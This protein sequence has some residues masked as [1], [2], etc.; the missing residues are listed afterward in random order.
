MRRSDLIMASGWLGLCLT[1]VLGGMALR[2][3]PVELE[4]L[5]PAGLGPWLPLLA[6]GLG[7]V[8]ALLLWVGA[9]HARGLGL[10]RPLAELIL[11][12]PLVLAY[13]WLVW[14]AGKL[15][16]VDWMFLAL[17]MLAALWLLR[18][19]RGSRPQPGSP[20]RFLPVDLTLILLPVVVGLAF[21]V[22]P[23]FRS[24][25][26]GFLGYP[27]YALVQMAVFLAIPAVRLRRL[28][29]SP[30]SAALM[31]AALFAL[32]HAP[33]PV[34]MP[35]TFV[36]MHLWAR[37]FLAG[38]RL[39]QLAVVMGLSATS[40][41]QFLSDDF[42]AHMKVGPGYLLDRAVD[43]MTA[44]EPPGYRPTTREYL[45]LA[46]PRTVGRK[47]TAAELDRW[48][49]DLAAARRPALAWSF[50]ASAEYARKAPERGWPAPPPIAEHWLDLDP[51]WRQ[52]IEEFGTAEYWSAAGGDFAGFVAS[53][54][55]GILRREAS[56]AEIAAWRP[57]PT[58]G[59]RRRLVRLLLEHRLEW[60]SSP[61]P[62]LPADEIRLGY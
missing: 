34:V 22:E 23:D 17:F 1:A 28:G 14:P 31:C 59:Q 30:A 15:R 27:L 53:L 26:L 50:Y 35:V 62:G 36:A 7:A 12:F 47:P 6:A 37:Q 38:R 21:G 41:T 61:Y 33:N 56:S 58:S 10:Q 9:G 54:Y 51:E 52:R 25:G 45:E 24:T 39:W 57:G 55:P 18:G 19:S 42:T 5:P 40:F 8:T 43:H 48:T 13:A 32:I 3:G 49:A 29:L 44:H 20:G 60:H 11:F 16:P 46:Y 4:V 2:L